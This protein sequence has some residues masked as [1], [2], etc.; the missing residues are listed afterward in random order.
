MSRVGQSVKVEGL[1]LV[2]LNSKDKH[3]KHELCEFTLF[4]VRVR[5]VR[6]SL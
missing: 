5:I 1:L 2:T 4:M 3:K 6:V